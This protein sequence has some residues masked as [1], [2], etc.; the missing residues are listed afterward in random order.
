M[1]ECYTTTI[2]N[3]TSYSWTQRLGRNNV[4]AQRITE[5]MKWDKILY[6]SQVRFE[7][8]EALFTVSYSSLAFLTSITTFGILDS[9]LPQTVQAVRGKVIR[10][11]LDTSSAHIFRY[12]SFGR[13]VLCAI[14]NS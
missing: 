6:P 13:W 3:L 7:Y 10:H 2:V 12:S 14:L 4:S 1:E 5:G 9:P 8:T 11:L